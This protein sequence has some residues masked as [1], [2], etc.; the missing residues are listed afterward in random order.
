MDSNNFKNLIG[1]RQKWVQSSK[2]NNFDFDSI[3]PG[4]YNDPSHFIYEILQNAEDAGAKEISFSLFDDRLEIVHDGKDFNFKDLNGITG[5]GIST[6]KDKINAIGKFGIG[7]KSVF[8]VTKTPIIH[9]G[10]YH[11]KIEDFV[12]PSSIASNGI[13]KTQI[14]LPFNHPSR[15]KE[16]VFKIVSR[17]VE[18]IGLKTLL[19]LKNIEEIKWHTPEKSGHYYKESKGVNNFENVHRISII[20]KIE[21]EEYFEEFLV[22][23][24][25]IKIDSSTLKV[26]VAYRVEKDDSEKDNIVKE[27]ESKLIV[28][29]PT[30]K[31]TY[32]NFLIQGPYKTT[33]NRGDIPL[34]D[35]QNQY[36]LE[37]TANLV[38]ESIP[39]IKKLDLLNVSF[40]EVLPI[41][42]NHSDE[43][44]YSSI[45]KEV[46]KKL[47]TEEAFLP[48]SKSNFTDSHSALLARGKELI[49]FLNNEDIKILFGKE[50]WIDTNIT[51]DRTRELR[52][53]LKN[54]LDIKE[55]DF[56]DFAVTI[57][58]EFIERKSDDWLIEFY[59]RLLDQRS[60]W[61]KKDNASRNAVNLRQKPIIRL[62]DNSHINPCDQNNKIQVYLPA[63]I[64]SKYRTV[65]ITLTK[66]ENSL[67]FLT[68]LGV[69]KPDIFAE[70]R[71]LVIQKYVN[72]EPNV[73]IE[74]YLEDFEKLLIAFQKDDP[75]KKKELIIDLKDLYI[76]RSTNSITGINDFRQPQE[77]YLKLEELIEYFKKYNFVFFVSDELHQRFSG[78]ED[79][80]LVFLT[81][82]GC[83][84]K[85]RRKQIEPNLSHEEKE[86]L[87][88]NRG[89]TREIH[90]IDYDYEGLENFLTD[91]T[92]KR[93][94]ILWKFLLKSIESCDKWARDD[95]FKGEYEWFRYYRYSKK[96]D[97]KFL[98]T[99]KNSNW[100]FDVNENIVSPNQI[101]LSGIND[102]YVKDNDN[103]EMLINILGFQ[104]DEIK[105][106]EERT[107]GKFIPKEEYEEYLKWRKEQSKEDD[108]W[109]PKVKAESVKPVVKEIVPQII[110]TP[111]HR[112]Q[113]PDNSTSKVPN[114]ETG[115]V[116]Q[117][118]SKKE[119]S[120]KKI[121]A[122]GE[123]GERHVFEYLYRKFVEEPDI[124]IIWLNEN[125]DVG[126]GYDFSI[127]SEGR[128]I[129]YIEVKSKIDE[130]P[131][132][133]EITGT[134]WEFARKLYN[135]N[136]G[137]KY[138]IYVVSNAGSENTKIGIIKNPTKLWKEGKLYAHPVCFKL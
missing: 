64:K 111:D 65:K 39:I 52:N 99:L 50:Y 120:T 29:F 62:A 32:L 33:P 121:K 41:E 8:A 117:E 67:K 126:K 132:L 26:E 9:S 10:S 83:E 12:I 72:P 77:V 27:N 79:Y 4:I 14:I 123:W 127:V 34:E 54:E 44:I 128:E 42:Q 137:D 135:E 56:E 7:F 103:I 66:N 75:D 92:K 73:D 20:S 19:F 95:F 118:K 129:E 31:V 15:T 71:E 134:Q 22:I 3:L 100:I 98:K 136:E 16:E 11:F 106:I 48:T 28:F 94:S 49:E 105:R 116:D 45:Y 119:R 81:D 61:A 55:V 57:T 85:P 86:K 68:D 30:E 122:I 131:Q 110:E 124:K 53:Y 97:S 101:T 90:T 35:E 2:E 88:D 76:I 5:I 82:I 25:P 96:Y 78:N 93:S 138:N 74:E 84:N 51:D 91:L 38:A 133:F 125:G 47:L 23:Q 104:V 18:S 40:L 43:L 114:E 87:R 113:H 21:Q 17:K 89:Y 59:S 80:F 130:E 69:T 36:I 108:I 24:K 112:G 60:L 46:K 37:E 63:D 70:I 1:I 58:K 6:K 115:L 109:N 107:G 13:K 102:C